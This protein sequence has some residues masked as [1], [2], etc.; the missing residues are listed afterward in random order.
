MIRRHEEY[1]VLFDS[2]ERLIEDKKLNDRMAIPL[3]DAALGMRV[4]NS[5]YQKQTEE[6]PHV[7]G[8]DLKVLAN[9]EIL[10]SHGEK[11]GR[12]YTAGRELVEARARA[13]RG[14]TVADPYELV[15]VQ[16]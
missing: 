5:R 3:F 8:R 10:V 2:V 14:G 4:T 1:G 15:A 9:I 6:S 13:R 11:R 7:A 16:A 12:H